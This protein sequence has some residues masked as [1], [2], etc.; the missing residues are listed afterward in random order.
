MSDGV[1]PVLFQGATAWMIIHRGERVEMYFGTR[2]EARLIWYKLRKPNA[3]ARQK[4][5]RKYKL[6]K[7]A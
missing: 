1:Y 3:T 5:N 4:R 7:V 6:R 2:N